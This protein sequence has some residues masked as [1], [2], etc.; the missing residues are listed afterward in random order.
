[1]RR[2][3]RI[4]IYCR[5]VVG[6]C[7]KTEQRHAK[8]M[9]HTLKQTTHDTYE[10]TLLQMYAVFYRHGVQHGLWASAC[11]LQWQRWLCRLRRHRRFWL[12]HWRRAHKARNVYEITF[13]VGVCVFVCLWINRRPTHAVLSC[14]CRSSCRRFAGVR[15]SECVVRRAGGAGWRVVAPTQ[16]QTKWLESAL[17]ML[18]IVLD[19]LFAAP[20]C[21]PVASG[22][23]N[24]ARIYGSYTIHGSDSAPTHSQHAAMHNVF[25]DFTRLERPCVGWAKY[26]R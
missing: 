19:F 7:R 6:A 9:E 10:R 11:C 8:D 26:G 12:V 23:M 1:M 4:E 2:F 5:R 17:S 21:L 3:G 14:G 13:S 22:K 24:I 25:G 16:A 15:M 18:S 20:T